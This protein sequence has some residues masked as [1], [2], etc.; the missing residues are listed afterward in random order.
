MG[1]AG[2]FG[3]CGAGRYFMWLGARNALFFECVFR[4]HHVLFISKEQFE[5]KDRL[6]G[7]VSYS[8]L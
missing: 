4:L 1:E 3:L 8:L 7:R 6:L 2:S 5:V